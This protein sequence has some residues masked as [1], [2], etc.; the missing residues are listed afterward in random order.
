MRQRLA[1]PQHD[2]LRII[3]PLPSPP[4]VELFSKVGRGLCAKGRV[5]RAD[6]LPR[7]AVAGG[8]G[9]EAAPGIPAMVKGGR[10]TARQFASGWLRHERQLRII[11]GDG[12]LL[13]GRQLARD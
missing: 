5:R 3:A 13:H 2:I 12:I 10:L 6:P 11:G 4:L 1:D 8:A 7:R 9:R